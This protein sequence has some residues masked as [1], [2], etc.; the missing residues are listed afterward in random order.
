MMR[1][2]L[3]VW[4]VLLTSPVCAEEFYL[5]K[6]VGLGTDVSPYKSG[7]A[8]GGAAIDLRSTTGLDIWMCRSAN[9]VGATSPIA[10]TKTLTEAFSPTVMALVVKAIGSTM[11]SASP[12]VMDLLRELLVDRGKLHASRNGKYAIYLGGDTPIWQ[13]TK[14]AYDLFHLEDHGLLADLYNDYLEPPIAWATTLAKETFTGPDGDLSGAT[15]VHTWTE[16]GAGGWSVVSTQ[17]TST[18]VP[19]TIARL[20]SPLSTDDMQVVA[21]LVAVSSTGGGFSRCGVMARK[22]STATLTYYSVFADSIATGF[23]SMKRVNNTPTSLATNIQDPVPGSD[24]IAIIVDGST[25]TGQVNG[26]TVLGPTTDVDITGNTYTGLYGHAS[27]TTTLCTLD[28]VMSHDYPIAFGSI[29]RR[30]S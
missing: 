5:A 8:P 20:E 25:I 3:M 21:D 17:A 22:D 12:T 23:E 18:T 15:F 6:T 29:R 16:I 19:A 26:V 4:I 13:A 24:R 9:L 30:H 14:V 7:C 11:T 28:N 1:C 10:L 2:G 27:S